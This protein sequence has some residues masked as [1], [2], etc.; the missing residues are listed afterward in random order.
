LHTQQV[1][2]QFPRNVRAIA[3]APH[4]ISFRIQLIEGVQ[5][6]VTRQRKFFGQLA[7]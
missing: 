1:N 6:G 7:R 2:G 3:Y 4:E 5:N